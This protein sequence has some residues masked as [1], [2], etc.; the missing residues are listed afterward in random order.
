M[1]AREAGGENISSDIDL[2]QELPPSI[3]FDKVIPGSPLETFL[4][5]AGN[6]AL[7]TAFPSVLFSQDSS[8]VAVPE[9][10]VVGPSSGPNQIPRQVNNTYMES[11]RKNYIT[12]KIHTWS[13]RAP[14]RLRYED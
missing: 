2:L 6:L 11:A 8:F 13:G 4:R 12:R 14:S 5:G 9:V 1:I 7:E 3:L 10:G